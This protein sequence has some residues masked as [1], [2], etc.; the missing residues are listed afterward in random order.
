MLLIWISSGFSSISSSSISSSSSIVPGGVVVHGRVSVWHV[1]RQQSVTLHITVHLLLEQKKSHKIWAN[2]E[3]R[4]MSCMS[5]TFQLIASQFPLYYRGVWSDLVEAREAV[6]SGELVGGGGF[7]VGGE[8]SVGGAAGVVVLVVVL[9]GPAAVGVQGPALQRHHGVLA[10]GR[11][12]RHRQEAQVRHEL[13]AEEEASAVLLYCGAAGRPSY[14]VKLHQC[15]I[16][17]IYYTYIYIYRFHIDFYSVYNWFIYLFDLIFDI[18]SLCT[19]VFYIYV[20]ISL[21]LSIYIYIYSMYFICLSIN[22]YIQQ[23]H[24]Y[25]RLTLLGPGPPQAEGDEG[26]DDEDQGAQDHAH[27]EVGQVAGPRHRPPG[28]L[29]PVDRNLRRDGAQVVRASWERERER[30]RDG[31]RERER[32]RETERE[33]ERERERDGEKQ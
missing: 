13:W 9:R 32:E 10:G 2:T 28:V 31:E 20:F 8:L 19:Y 1:L 4:E 12:R 7:A 22:L 3:R 5:F 30:E 17:F 16:C 15:S 11:G 21:I 26:H 29:R 23:Q 18:L 33:R 24:G 6:G 27:D 14:R 25:V